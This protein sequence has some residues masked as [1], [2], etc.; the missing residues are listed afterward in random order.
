MR[1]RN[2]GIPVMVGRDIIK[3][4]RKKRSFVLT[5]GPDETI[6]FIPEDQ[7]YRDPER[8]K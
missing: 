8:L 5:V 3:S 4:I 7:R 6:T 1:N 2:V